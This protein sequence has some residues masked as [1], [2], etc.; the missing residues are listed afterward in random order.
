MS[1]SQALNILK[2]KSLQSKCFRKKVLR[3]FTLKYELIKDLLIIY[4]GCQT[5]QTIHIPSKCVILVMNI[6]W[7]VQQKIFQDF[8][9]TFVDLASIKFHILLLF[10]MLDIILKCCMIFYIPLKTP[11]YWACIYKNCSQREWNMCE[12]FSWRSCFWVW[13][14]TS[15]RAKGDERMENL[16]K[17]RW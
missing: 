9:P 10:T 4:C 3:F 11:T 7:W 14:R 5:K 8:S 13:C 2:Q 16:E 6:I 15:G 12:I 1:L 17:T